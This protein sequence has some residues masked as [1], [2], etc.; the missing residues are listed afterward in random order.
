VAVVPRSAVTD[1]RNR[2]LYA[3]SVALATDSA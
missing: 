3:E 1:R 2:V